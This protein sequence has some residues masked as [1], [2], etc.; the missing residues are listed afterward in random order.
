[1]PVPCIN[2]MP[3]LGTDQHPY[4]LCTASVLCSGWASGSALT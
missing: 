3:H 2:T 4:L 1:M